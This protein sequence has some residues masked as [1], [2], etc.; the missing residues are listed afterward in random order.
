[1]SVFERYGSKIIYCQDKGM[2]TEIILFPF[3]LLSILYQWGVRLRIFLYNQG[4]LRKERLPCTVISVGNLTVGGTGKT[5]TVQYIAQFLKEE[6]K[7]PVILSRGYKGKIKGKVQALS[8]GGGF[9]PGYGKVGDEPLLL[10][11]KLVTV[12]VVVGKDRMYTGRYALKEFSPDALLLDDGFQYLK[13]VRDCNIV[14]IDVQNGFGNGHVLPRGILREPVK[15]LQ[16]ADLVLLNKGSSSDDYLRLEKE[17]RKWNVAAPIFFSG[18]QIVSISGLKE[19]EK[20]P[21]EFLQGKKVMTLSGIANPR[22]F[23]LLLTQLGAEIVSEI[24]FPDHHF[25]SLEDL[26]FI[27]EKSKGV[28]LIITTEKDGIKLRQKMFENLPLFMVE[29]VLKVSREEEFKHYLLSVL[30]KKK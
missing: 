3:M 26:P 13:M 28:E 20:Y 16:R 25:Y 17:I 7:N 19:G 1:M 2:R 14:V 9:L 24:S 11:Q 23:H 22:Y 29:V 6:G 12:P 8:S 5:P 4:I 27:R 10:F 30:W 15:A 21:P 18:Y